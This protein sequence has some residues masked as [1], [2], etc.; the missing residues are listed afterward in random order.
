MFRYLGPDAGNLI[1]MNETNFVEWKLSGGPP[2]KEGRV[3][4]ESNIINLSKNSKK[5]SVKTATKR[6]QKTKK[7]K[8][9]QKTRSTRKPK[10]SNSKNS[11][12]SESPATENL[13]GSGLTTVRASELIVES[14]DYSQD[15]EINANDITYED[16][17]Y[18]DLCMNPEFIAAD[19]SLNGSQIFLFKDDNYYILEGLKFVINFNSK[20]LTDIHSV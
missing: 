14:E 16:P 7:T 8:R 3:E 1:Q 15:D 13:E 17:I 9:P 10:H 19:S 6:P 11:N 18:R 5:I 20:T 12:N 4:N 2:I